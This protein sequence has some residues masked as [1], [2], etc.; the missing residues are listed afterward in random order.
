MRLCVL[1]SFA[2]GAEFCERVIRE[3]DEWDL[4]LDSGAFT[5]WSTGKEVVA[6]DDYCAFLGEC[7]SRFGHY[8]NLDV[9]GD[10]A[11]TEDN[12]RRMQQA[13]LK[14]APVFTR[15]G[16]ASRLYGLLRE[17]PLVFVGGISKQVNARAERD[18]VKQVMSVVRR[19]G[20][21]AHLLGMTGFGA[22]SEHKPWSADSSTWS[23]VGR[24]GKAPLWDASRRRFI[25]FGPKDK[26]E[27]AHTRILRAYGL[28]WKGLHSPEGW[29]AKTKGPG[30]CVRVAGARSGIRYSRTLQRMG[31]RL[32]LANSPVFSTHETLTAAWEAE[33]A[34]W[35]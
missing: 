5:N 28:D 22:L 19:S 21:R 34:L 27:P 7:G 35:T 20:G 9:V 17:H 2:W 24:Y 25:I 10:A 31:T 18:Y 14:P 8:L 13:G 30:G 6:L 16:S 12:M 15:G 1:I 23:L 26:P 11:A 29:R 32:Y 4:I 33:R 3:H